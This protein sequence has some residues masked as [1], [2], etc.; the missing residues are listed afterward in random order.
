FKK[1]GFVTSIQYDTAQQQ[2]QKL[3]FILTDRLYPKATQYTYY[4]VNNKVYGFAAVVNYP[5]SKP[6]VFYQ[7]LLQGFKPFNNTT[8]STVFVNK[9][10]K[11]V[12][13]YLQAGNL[14][15]SD[16]AE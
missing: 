5:N 11:L 9:I 15:Q 6:S 1:T 3:S 8:A 7:N 2:S 4:L 13:A 14:A 16:L 10:D 12:S